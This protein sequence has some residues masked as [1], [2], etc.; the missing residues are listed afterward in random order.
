[1]S[2]ARVDRHGAVSAPD[3]DPRRMKLLVRLPNHLGDTLMAL[4][5]LDRLTAAGHA[6]TLVGKGWA[7]ALFAAYD[8]TVEPVA[9]GWGATVR[10]WR[11]LKATH[12][13][14]ALMLTNSFGTALAARVAGLRV[15]AYAT[16]GRGPF[17]SRAVIVPRRWYAAGSHMHTVEYYDALAAA[18]LRERVR[19]PPALALRLTA[20]AQSRARALLREAGGAD[21]AN[22]YIVLCPGATG[23]HR[24]RDKTW[25]EFPRLCRWLIQQGRTV[26]AQPGPGERPRFEQALPG[27]TLLPEADVA[28]FAALL[29]SSQLVVANDSGPSHVA[30]AVGAPLVALFG[31]TE[32]EK[33]RPWSDRATVVG[34]QAGWPSFDEVAAVVQQRLAADRT[35]AD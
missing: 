26:V 20:Q 27:A 17:L 7:R 31:V 34:S 12:D 24:G 9:T 29:A 11:A 13:G 4:T 22:D 19:R 23:R 1:M 15:T 35:A 14:D 8:W 3:H 16:D 10:Q 2:E 28:T 33:T 30:A 25:S 18:Y 32:L 5:A 6:L 21:A